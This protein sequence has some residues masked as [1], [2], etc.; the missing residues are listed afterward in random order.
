MKCEQIQEQ[1][2]LLFGSE[3]LPEEI[4]Q[5]LESCEDCR[6]HHQELLRLSE[7]LGVDEDFE[8]SA[9]DLE[10]AVAGVG[11]RIDSQKTPSIVPVS[12]LRQL[13]RIAAALLIVGVSYTTYL[14]GQKQGQEPVARV[15]DTVVASNADTVEMDDYFVSML[16]EDFSSDAYFGAG[17]ILLDDLTEDELEYLTEN[18]TVG[19]LL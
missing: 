15:V 2:D 1:L 13:S 5:H 3:Q 11:D 12:R 14:I 19:D 16:I 17:E 4:Q 7:K 6:A 9:F 8:P 10:Q 18:M